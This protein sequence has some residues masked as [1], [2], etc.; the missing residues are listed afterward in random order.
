M[1]NYRNTP[2]YGGAITC[3]LPKHFADVRCAKLT[4]HPSRRN[5][6]HS[7]VSVLIEYYFLQQAETGSRQPGSMDR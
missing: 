5:R 2:L 3:D 6:I 1:A 4:T 7:P